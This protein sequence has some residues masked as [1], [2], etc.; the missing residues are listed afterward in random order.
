MKS[1]AIDMFLTGQTFLSLPGGTVALKTTRSSLSSNS[2]RRPSKG[3]GDYFVDIADETAFV[4]SYFLDN[5]AL[6]S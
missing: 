3:S 5:T 2:A 4:L 6:Q 1:A